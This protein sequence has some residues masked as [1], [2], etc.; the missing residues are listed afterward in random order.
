MKPLKSYNITT[1]TVS[2][3]SSAPITVGVGTVRLVATGNPAWVTIGNSPTAAATTSFLIPVNFPEYFRCAGN[4]V[5]KVAA[6]QN[7]GAGSVNVTEMTQ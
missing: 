4:G 3:V 7:T 1:G 2:A 5:E 6:I